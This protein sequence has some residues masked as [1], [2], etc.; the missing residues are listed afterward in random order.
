MKGMPNRRNI[1]AAISLP[2][3]TLSSG[4]PS[5]RS[6]FISLP[7]LPRDL[8]H[9]N[10]E[11]PPVMLPAR[12]LLSHRTGRACNPPRR[13][14]P[15]DRSPCV[16]GSVRVRLK[17][18]SH[19]TNFC[20]HNGKEGLATTVRRR[21]PMERSCRSNAAS[22]GGTLKLTSTVAVYEVKLQQLTRLRLRADGV[23]LLA[24]WTGVEDGCVDV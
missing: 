22:T 24:V 1:C 7:R 5:I 4:F 8:T 16:T 18:L 9:T 17:R 19:Y 10:C 12:P 21:L 20:L 13:G 23:C 2:Q 6:S 15:R 3:A 14:M 11:I